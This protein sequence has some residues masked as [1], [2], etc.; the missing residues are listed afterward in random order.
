[1]DRTLNGKPVSHIA[2]PDKTVLYFESNF[3]TANSSG[4]QRDVNWTRHSASRSNICVVSGSCRTIVNGSQRT[5]LSWTAS[6]R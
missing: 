2:D 6:G 5:D 3:G 4:T 1:M